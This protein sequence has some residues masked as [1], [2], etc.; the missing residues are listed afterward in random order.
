MAFGH[1][2][3]GTHNSMVTARGSCV[4]WPLATEPKLARSGPNEDEYYKFL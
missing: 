2:L 3:L 1:F 4:K